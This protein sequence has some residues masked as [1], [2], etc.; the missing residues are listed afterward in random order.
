[1]AKLRLTNDRDRPL[2]LWVEPLGEDYWLS[3]KETFT[4]TVE[5][6]PEADGFT[7]IHHDQGVSVWFEAAAWPEPRVYDAGGRLLECGHHRSPKATAM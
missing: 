6:T 1:M 3:P 7:V 2:G 4:I 5:D